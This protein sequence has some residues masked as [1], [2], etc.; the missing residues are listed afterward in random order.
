MDANGFVDQENADIP[1]DIDDTNATIPPTS[2]IQSD[3]Q[4]ENA[5]QSSDFSVPEKNKN[6]LYPDENKNASAIERTFG[7]LDL[8]AGKQKSNYETYKE[9]DTAYKNSQTNGLQNTNG[10]S[11]IG[12]ANT[13][14]MN[15][16]PNW[17]EFS[18]KGK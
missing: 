6:S 14:S 18:K 2:N 13:T 3:V 15:S 9:M 16:I 10:I 1:P 12:A 11:G 17:K 7:S 8:S 5:Q 4:N